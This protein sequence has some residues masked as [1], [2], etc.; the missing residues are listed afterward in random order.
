MTPR[1]PNHHEGRWTPFTA[2]DGHFECT[3]ECPEC[4]ADP[5][6]VCKDCTYPNHDH[7][8]AA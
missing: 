8:R 1:K 5:E 4:W 6:C 2:P 3:C 7:G